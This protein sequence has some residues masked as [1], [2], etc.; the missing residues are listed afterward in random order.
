MPSDLALNLSRR[1]V[2]PAARRNG[3]GREC[4]PPPSERRARDWISVLA[5][6]DVRV[7]VDDLDGVISLR[8]MLAAR[9]MARRSAWL[10]DAR[11]RAARHS[12][13]DLLSVFSA[14]ARH[15]RAWALLQAEIDADLAAL[16]VSEARV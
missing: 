13:G 3:V 9:L 8:P 5:Y 2:T 4:D 16:S 14:N 10:E 15:A 1:T 12:L 7:L 11:R 6:R